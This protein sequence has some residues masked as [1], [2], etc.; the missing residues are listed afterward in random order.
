MVEIRVSAKEGFN[1]SHEGS[2]FVVLNTSLTEDLINEGVVREFI[3]KI[4]NLRK[5]KDFEITDRINVYYQENSELTKAISNYLDL[6][7]DE[8]VA[9][10]IIEK[11]VDTESVNLNGLDVKFDV[12]RVSK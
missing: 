3:S 1:A 4:Q 5:V 7:K 12:E 11:D 10:E 2:N 8:T 6:I 9:I